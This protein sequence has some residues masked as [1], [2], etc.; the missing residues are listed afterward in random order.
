MSLT[1]QSLG[2]SGEEIAAHHLTQK[3]YK[4]LERNFRCGK[5]EVDLII[6]KDEVIAFVEVKLRR[7]TGYG[8]PLEAITIAKQKELAKAA[9]CYIRKFPSSNTIY[10]FDVVGIL[11]DGI[12]EE[13]THLEDAF[14]L[15]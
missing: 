9:E 2:R 7:S 15:F 8:H 4:V 14:R 10:R 11:A 1:N 5:N 12:Q 3:G 13:I 6:R